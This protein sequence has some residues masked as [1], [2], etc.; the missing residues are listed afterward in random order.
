VIVRC[1][2]L[3]DVDQ[4]AGLFDELGHRQTDDALALALEGALSD[5]RAGV[6]VADDGGALVG[7]ATYFLVPV[8]HDSGPS[9]RVTTLVVD[10]AHRGHGIGHRLVEAAEA[11]ARG[12]GC[13]RIEATSALHRTGAHRFYDGL[14]YGRT[15][16]HF[17]KR[18]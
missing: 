16:A 12:A 9:C 4:L 8:L 11:V 7:A 1:A 17:L 14:G 3:E 13:S 6:L 10:E 18:L 5:P 15:S 2:R